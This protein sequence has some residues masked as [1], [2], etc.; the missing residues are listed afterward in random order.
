MKRLVVLGLAAVLVVGCAKRLVKPPPEAYLTLGGKKVA[1]R[2]WSRVE[3]LCAID[4]KQFT[5]E[6]QALTALLAD[7]LGQTSAPAEGAW[8]DEHLALLEDGARLLP[9]ALQLQHEA[10]EKTAAAPCTFEGLGPAREL[11][12]Q[13]QRRVAEAPWL[14]EQ[15]RARRALAQWKQDQP[16]AMQRARETSCATKMKPPAPILFYAA[17]D[18][19]AKLEWL[20]CDGSKV[21]A[22]PGNP[23]AWVPD[24]NAKKTKKEPDPK[25][26]LDVAA[27][28]PPESVARAPKLPKRRVVKDDATPEPE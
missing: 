10:L 8:D 4:G 22:S 13:A 28:Y 14:L 19:T 15:L 2:A 16:A 18:E 24:P 17:E 11:N 1:Y 20:F 12:A 25:V 26:W 23:P 21:V 3:D 27:K 9:P 7:W 5:A 6:Q